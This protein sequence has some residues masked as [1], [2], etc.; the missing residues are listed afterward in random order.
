M[1]LS[2]DECYTFNYSWCVE[3]SLQQ[4][5]F[6]KDMY[7]INQVAINFCQGVRLVPVNSI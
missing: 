1:T 2:I 5:H 6:R 3:Y 7:E 4:S